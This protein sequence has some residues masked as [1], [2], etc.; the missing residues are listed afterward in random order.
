MYDT[1]VTWQI[2]NFETIFT[3]IFLTVFIVKS[4]HNSK[5]IFNIIIGTLFLG[6][7]YSKCAK[8]N[9]TKHQIG[10]HD[11]VL[12][13]ECLWSLFSLQLRPT[14]RE[15]VGKLLS[16]SLQLFFSRNRSLA[17]VVISGSQ[18]V[19]CWGAKT[20]STLVWCLSTRAVNVTGFSSVFALQRDATFVVNRADGALCK[21]IHLFGMN[22]HRMSTRY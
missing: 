5:L 6:V 15:S 13:S 16:C 1:K 2:S 7:T 14:C 21:R 10:T 11:N 8:C 18:D 20:N 17:F 19:L 22:S 9:F 12:R 4:I 3:I